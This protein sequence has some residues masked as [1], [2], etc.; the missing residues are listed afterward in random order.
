MN[1]TKV[2]SEGTNEMKYPRRN[3]LTESRADF[4][5]SRVKARMRRGSAKRTRLTGEMIRYL[6]LRN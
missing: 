3:K 1:T 2:R 4:M 5:Q 6:C